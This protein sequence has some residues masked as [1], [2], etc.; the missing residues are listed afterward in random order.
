MKEFKDINQST[1]AKRKIKSLAKNSNLDLKLVTLLANVSWDYDIDPMFS[2]PLGWVQDKQL[3]SNLGQTT[4]KEIANILHIGSLKSEF[5]I[6]NILISYNSINKNKLF[7]N[8]L[9]SGKTNNYAYLSE[10]A[11]YHYLNNLTINNLKLLDF[12]I[13]YSIV[14][15]ANMLFRKIFNG[16]AVNRDN[17]IYCYCDLWI[18]LPYLETPEINVSDWTKNV[19]EQINDLSNKSTLSDLINC[20][21]SEIKGNK[22]FR[23]EIL[24]ALTYSRILKVKNIET[25]DL[26]I[27]QYRNE[28]STNFYSNEWTYPLRFWNEIKTTANKSNRCTNP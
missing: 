5:L 1:S 13:E 9:V 3:K 19:I 16:G 11:T 25:R 14:D 6:E 4:L 18:K 20:T 24:Q 10:Y 7:Q 27:P 22:N 26:F 2:E 15:V 8:F 23:Q 21:K 17:L 28:L 12:K